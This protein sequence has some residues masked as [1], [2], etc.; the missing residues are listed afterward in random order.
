MSSLPCT[1]VL[2]SSNSHSNTS[3][4]NPNSQSNT[5]EGIVNISVP[6]SNMYQRHQSQ[7]EQVQQRSPEKKVAEKPNKPAQIVA[8]KTR[9]RDS[10]TEV[11][12]SLAASALQNNSSA[13]LNESLRPRESLAILKQQIQKPTRPEQTSMDSSIISPGKLL[14]SQHLQSMSQSDQLSP[15]RKKASQI[16]RISNHESKWIQPKEGILSK[17]PQL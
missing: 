14:Q 12:R 13:S 3:L 7:P 1:T 2:S 17:A 6:T 10:I 11:A 16:S 15:P 8:P 4:P 5:T 9:V